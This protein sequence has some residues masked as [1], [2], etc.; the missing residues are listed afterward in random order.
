MKYIS[1][2]AEEQ[3]ISYFHKVAEVALRSSCFRAKCGAIIV[4]D[5][6]IIGF[7]FNSPPKDM[8]LEY[9]IKD[10]LPTGFSS[11]RTCCV[12]AEERAIIDALKN[13]HEKLIDSRLYFIRLDE[14]G[15][16]SRS[17]KPYC[18]ICS[19]LALDVGISEFCLWHDNGICV[20]GAK[21]Y[22]ELSFKFIK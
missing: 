20:Y 14:H 15:A 1:G 2:V 17:G 6:S 13:Y 8:L 18:T 4:K 22:N 3:A 5:D 12:H 7:G 21:E 9:C 10:I 11:D 19:K 16:L